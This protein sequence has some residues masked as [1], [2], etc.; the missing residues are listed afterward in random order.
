MNLQIRQ[1]EPELMDQPGLSDA[2]HGSALTGLSRV[3][4]FSRSSSIFWGPLSKLAQTIDQ[5]PVKILDIASGGGDVSIDLAMRAR[6]TG[7]DIEISGCDISEYAVRHA[8]ERA[9]QKGLEKIHFF[10]SDIFQEPAERRYDLVMCSL[11]LH[12]LDEPQAVQLMQ[13]MSESTRHLLL[14]NDLRRTRLGYWLAWCGCRLLTRSPIVHTDGPI[15]VAAAF[16]I[17]E[18]EQLARQAGLNQV[19]ISR[20]WPQRFLLEWSRV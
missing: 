14:I 5:R 7:L 12:H 9:Q 20:H 13:W 19:Q 16:S 2:E 1:R 15:S 10:Q 6:Q 11:F 4:W 3:N 17:D 18:T 8:T